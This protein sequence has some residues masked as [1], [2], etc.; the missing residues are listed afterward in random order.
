MDIKKFKRTKF[1]CYTAYFTMSSV[2]CLPPL[3]FVPFHELYSISWTL[4][5][6]LVLTNFCTQLGV[7]IVFS[8]F[9]KKFNLEKI[10]KFIPLITTVGMLLYAILPMIFPANAYA[11]LLIGTFIFSIASGL[12]EALLS[13]VMAA[14]PSENPQKDMSFLHSLYAFGVFTVVIIGTLFVKIVGQEYWHYLVMFFA[15]LPVS[16][17]VLF[18]VSPFPDMTANEVAVKGEKGKRTIIGLALCFGCIFLGSCAENNMSSWISS[19]MDEQLHIDKALG[20]ILGLA[21]F[22]VLLGI[23]RIAYAKWGKNITKTLL[24]GMISASVCYLVAGLTTAVVP[25][26]IACV[27]TGIFTAMLWPGTL[28]LM[29]ENMPGVGVVGYAL[30]AAGGDLGA[31]V[32]PQ[33][34]GIIS[35]HAGMQTG[36]LVCSI[37]PILG[38]VLV[39]VIMRFFKK[40]PPVLPIKQER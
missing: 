22:A 15:V 35:D 18:I 28:I 23:M 7:D 9:S 29:E 21:G 4:L 12:S 3:L 10:V 6:T 8:L 24:I 33:L 38:T 25:S 39:L 16:A 19:Y 2:F 17:S 37:F 36:M 30:M 11:W 20:D 34:M 5:G 27:M 14:I 40:N 26:F 1:A 32:A 13:P 31:S